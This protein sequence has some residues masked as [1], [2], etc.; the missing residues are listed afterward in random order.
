MNL[1][2]KWAECPEDCTVK[3]NV[4]SAQSKTSE[5]RLKFSPMSPVKG[6]YK[7]FWCFE[8]YWQSGKVFE[9]DTDHTE[10]VKWWKKLEVPKRRY[11]KSKG[12]KVLY[13]IYNGKKMD[14]ITA[15]K[16][17]YVPEYYEMIKDRVKEEKHRDITVYDFDG[18]RK[19]DGDVDCKEVTQE[20]LIEKLN[21]TSR[22]FGHG[23]I[24][25]GIL[26]GIIKEPVWW[27]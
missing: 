3:M 16:E 24:V 5:N 12:K 27:E 23:Y 13:G 11:P 22:P 18:P 7:G 15:R 20:L 4:T 25:A 21:D 14:Y 26:A 9:D 10:T 2:G 17:V 1:R 19:E 6:G 8:N